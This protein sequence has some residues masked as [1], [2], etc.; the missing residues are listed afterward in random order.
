MK[1]LATALLVSILRAPQY[2]QETLPGPFYESPESRRERLEPVA[3]ELAEHAASLFEAAALIELGKAETNWARYV[4]ERGCP[5]RPPKSPNC[6]GGRA[7][8]PFQLHRSA[9]ARAWAAE[10][11]S[12]EE[13]HES[14]LCAIRLMRAGYRKCGDL[15]GAF[16]FYG[17]RGCSSPLGAR[18]ADEHAT[19]W[20]IVRIEHA[21]FK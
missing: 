8:G 18:R 5:N 9:C 10:P 17:A 1:L 19:V 3:E 2:Y 14:T 6:D 16:A 4:S 12:R 13:L 21:R 7:L 15:P 20:K 11:G